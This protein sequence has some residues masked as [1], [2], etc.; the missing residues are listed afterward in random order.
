MRLGLIRESRAMTACGRRLVAILRISLVVGYRA[1]R[2]A[3]SY[4]YEEADELQ[5][6]LEFAG[7]V[8]S[9]H[10]PDGP[11][12]VTKELACDSACRAGRRTT[13]GT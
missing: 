12:I 10:Q 7:Y 1:D 13:D 6:D 3:N 2:M 5:I 9:A 4:L 8:P 11:V